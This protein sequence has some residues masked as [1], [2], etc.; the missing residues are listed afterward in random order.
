MLSLARPNPV[1][2]FTAVREVTGIQLF[3]L[4]LHILFEAGVIVISVVDT[5]RS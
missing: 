4:G 5:P 1:R 3:E 2:E